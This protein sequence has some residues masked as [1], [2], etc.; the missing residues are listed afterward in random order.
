[1]VALVTGATRGVGLGIA[2]GL[3]EGG[4]TVYLSGRGPL[5]PGSPLEQ[6]ADRVRAVG[7]CAVP[8]VCDH[9]DDQQVTALVERV[10]AEQG[11]LDVLVNNVW[12]GPRIEAAT[13]LPS[14]ERPLS[15]WDPLIGLG[16]RAHFVATVAACRPMVDRRAGLIV[17]VSSFGAR[18]Y[19][20]SVLYGVA[21]AG[22]DK[23]TAD[24]AH[25]LAGFDVTALS[26]WPGLVRTPALLARGTTQVAGV[27][28]EE[29]ESPEFQGRV[30]HALAADP[31][32]ARWNGAAVV[33]A[34][35]GRHYGVLDVDGRC[36]RSL[37]SV[38]GGGPLFVDPLGPAAEGG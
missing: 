33:S 22:L 36:P 5:V 20:H 37:R 3:G 8:V 19:L 16:L 18:A 4:A 38:F 31:G 30:V 32:V 27:P 13:A 11:R 12:A 2:T 24:L 14:W 1:M 23:M 9:R 10:V 25:E 21:K 28:V 17:S 34:E 35:V 15:D 26:L 6:A 29:G 7:G